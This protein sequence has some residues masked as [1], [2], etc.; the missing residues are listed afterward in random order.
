M[1]LVFQNFKINKNQD[2]FYQNFR[3]KKLWTKLVP[4]IQCNT[5]EYVLKVE[6]RKGHKMGKDES[7]IK[8]KRKGRARE[9]GEE[10]K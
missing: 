6:E 9:G 8:E 2:F 5:C 4:I 1:K 3:L 7:Y 10:G